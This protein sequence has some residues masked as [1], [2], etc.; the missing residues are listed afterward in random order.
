MTPTL[1]RPIAGTLLSSGVAMA[2]L[3][4][5]AGTAQA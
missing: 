2:G 3:G 1:K 5:I 4:L